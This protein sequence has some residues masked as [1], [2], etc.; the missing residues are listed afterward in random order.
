MFFEK[1]HEL[2]DSLLNEEKIRAVAQVEYKYELE[3]E[4]EI[5]AAEQAKI[6]LA[7]Q[8]EM[9]QQRWIQYSTLGGLVAIVII[10]GIIYRSYQIK[11][12]DNFTL[13]AQANTLKIQAEELEAQAEELIQQSDTLALKNK[14]LTA[15]RAKEQELAE[16]ALTSKEREL[17]TIAMTS[18]EKKNVLEEIQSKIKH[19]EEKIHQEL[20]PEVKAI[21]KII[22][23]NLKLDDSWD[24]F[25]HR[26]GDVHPQFFENLKARNTSLTIKDLKM[27]A[28]LKI[29]MS[30]KEIANV[31]NL[32]VG[33]V[34]ISI[35]RLKKKLTLTA[36]DSI[37]D[38]MLNA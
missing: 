38:F 10:A 26:F 25:L 35:N 9:Q 17:A 28:Y 30:N 24:S 5:M 32:T 21:K 18:F 14:E 27:S 37:R 11:K 4:K 8:Q 19:L 12:Q 1:Y 29:G 31:T 20:K 22:S 16:E 3:K 2:A 34:K 33:S 36:E 13:A 6:D 7:H 15:L 23:H